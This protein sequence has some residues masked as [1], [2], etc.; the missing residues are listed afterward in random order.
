MRAP[1][2][3]LEIIRYPQTDGLCMFFDT[4]DYRTAHFHPEWEILL[5]LENALL[6]HT[7][8]E[9]MTLSPGEMVLFNPWQA[10]EFHRVEESCTALFLQFST[11]LFSMAFPKT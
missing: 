6:I 9:E 8:G 4:I 5:V 11:E 7:A 3:E 10:H 1:V 2:H